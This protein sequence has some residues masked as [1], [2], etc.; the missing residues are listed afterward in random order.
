M[1]LEALQMLAAEMNNVIQFSAPA[2]VVADTAE[3]ALDMIFEEMVIDPASIEFR[4]ERKHRALGAIRKAYRA[5]EIPLRRSG[6]TSAL[7]PALFTAASTS[8]FITAMPFSSCWSFRLPN[9]EAWGS[10]S[11]RGSWVSF[12]S[13]AARYRWTR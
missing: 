13:K 10:R 12:A 5:R 9:Q 2:P 4:F 8:L 3:G 7:R 6:N 11:R 1:S